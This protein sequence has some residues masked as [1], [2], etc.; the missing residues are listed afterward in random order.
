M[1]NIQ[2]YQ[3]EMLDKRAND[4]DLSALTEA[5]STSK[6]AIWKLWIYIVSFIA[7]TQ[8]ELNEVNKQENTHLIE[9]QRRL[10]L[11]YY[12]QVCLDYRDGHT[13]NSET[14]SYVDTYT[15]EEIATAQIVKRAAVKEATE[16]TA[17]FIELKLAT[18]IGGELAAIPEV[19]LNRIKQHLFI[20]GDAGASL[21]VTSN[22]ADELRL[23][24]DVYIDTQILNLSGSRVDGKAN[25]VVKTAIDDFF[26][27]KSFKFDGELVLSML[28]DAI[29]AVDGVLDRSVSIKSAEANYKIPA[30]WEQINERY[31]SYS[32]Y[33]KIIDGGLTINYKVK[34]D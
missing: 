20:N 4:A 28:V 27:D 18:E 22:R 16:G 15:D 7:N 29:Q 6:V 33:F 23:T 19:Q 11:D 24:I 3:Q 17:K 8:R 34:E 26:A 31:T 1:S 21:R 2:T 25:D 13:F 14:L 10:N 32:G 9:N 30:E 5:D 12:R